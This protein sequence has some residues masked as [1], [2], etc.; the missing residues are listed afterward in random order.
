MIIKT[1]DSYYKVKT[2]YMLVVSVETKT[3]RTYQG[4][5]KPSKEEKIQ[6]YTLTMKFLSDPEENISTATWICPTK[7]PLIKL[8]DE[9]EEQVRA[10]DHQW[11]DEQFEN[12][13]RSDGNG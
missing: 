4:W 2:V 8:K 9:I 3:K 6:S 7:E 10:Q 1:D 11:V 12:A 5:F 13:L